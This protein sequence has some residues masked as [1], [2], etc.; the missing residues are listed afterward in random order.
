MATHSSI[1][2]WRSPWT[3]RAWQALVHG[4]VKSWTQLKQL[5]MLGHEA[6]V[7]PWESLYCGGGRDAEGK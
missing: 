4:V 6:A 1:P 2:A 7:Q 3:D 5:R